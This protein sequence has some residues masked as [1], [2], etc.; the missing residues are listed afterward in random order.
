MAYAFHF[1]QSLGVQTVQQAVYV[2]LQGFA[3]F[4]II[5]APVGHIGLLQQPV[6]QRQPGVEG[7]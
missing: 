2:A 3:G 1:G 7:H 6:V 5:Q 4:G